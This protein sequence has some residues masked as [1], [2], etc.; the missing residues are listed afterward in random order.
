MI[1]ELRHVGLVVTDMEK[2]LD[3]GKTYLVLSL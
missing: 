3:F 2:A 1:K